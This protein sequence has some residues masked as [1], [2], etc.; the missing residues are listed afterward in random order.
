MHCLACDAE[1]ILIKVVQDDTILV[2]GFEWRTFKCSACDDEERRLVFSKR[3]PE[4]TPVPTA[5]SIADG[6]SEN[7]PVPPMDT[8]PS[9]AD[10]QSENKPMPPMDTAPSIADVQS[11]NE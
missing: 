5:P 11:E 9:I 10:R 1:M 3:D 2:P 8:A 4:P 7:E 6:Q